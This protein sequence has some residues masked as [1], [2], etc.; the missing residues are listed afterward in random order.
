ML[1]VSGE[2]GARKK[3]LKHNFRFF[4]T[5]IFPTIK[6]HQNALHEALS[7]LLPNDGKGDQTPLEMLLLL[8]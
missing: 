7:Y 2:K 6:S 1:T 8:K 5:C 3:N 4:P